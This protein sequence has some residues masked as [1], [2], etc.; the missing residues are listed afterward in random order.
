[1]QIHSPPSFKGSHAEVDPIRS[2]NDAVSM[3]GRIGSSGQRSISTSG[4][5]SATHLVAFVTSAH[6]LLFSGRD[7]GRCHADA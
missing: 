7:L 2:V 1:M 3:L 5:S 4:K 6:P